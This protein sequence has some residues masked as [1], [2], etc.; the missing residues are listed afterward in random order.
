MTVTSC[1]TCTISDMSLTRRHDSS[2]ALTQAISP[3]EVHEHAEPFDGRNHS[4]TDLPVLQS[5]QELQNGLNL[6]IFDH[7]PADATGRWL[8]TAIS[9]AAPQGIRPL[10][11]RGFTSS[12]PQGGRPNRAAPLQCRTKSLRQI[13][14]QTHGYPGNSGRGTAGQAART[15]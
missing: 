15:R 5:P 4:P 12:G 7:I 2:A 14:G 10:R 8:Q 9:S 13:I 1:P 6:P 3:T 11:L